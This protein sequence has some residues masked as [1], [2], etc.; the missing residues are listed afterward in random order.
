MG[1]LLCAFALGA[2]LIAPH[3]GAPAVM[4]DGKVVPPMSMLV[5]VAPW[6]AR[7][8]DAQRAYY[9]KLGDAGMRVFY[10]TCATSWRNP[11]DKAKGWPDGAHEAVA[12]VR[13]I[14]ASVPEA[15][16]I[17]RLNVSPPA[18]WVEAHPEEM[19]T[20]DD[21]SHRPVICTTIGGKPLSGMLS[22]CS[23]KWRARGAEALAAFFKVIDASDVADRVIGTF[24]CAGG[25]SEWYYPI[26]MV[27]QDGHCAGFCE[28][29]RAEYERYLRQKYG[30]VEAL[31]K[32][33]RRPEATF[34]RP[35]VPT[36]DE[37]DHV[38]KADAR[39]LG[40]LHSWESASRRIGG[41][42]KSA[43]ASLGVFLDLD[44]ASHVADFYD[45]WHEGVANTIVHF[46]RT[47]KAISPDRLV[48]AFYG[49]LGETGYY[50]L[51][52][53]TGTLRILDSGVVDFLAAPGTYN[54]REPGGI[55]AQR[56]VPDSFRLRNCIYIC[57]D[58]SRTHLSKPWMQRDAMA[59]YTAAESVETL[60]RDF[61][62]NL[63]EGLYGWWFDMGNGWYEDADILR[64]FRRQQEIAAEAYEARREKRNEI[65]LV[66]SLRSVHVVSDYTSKL[67]LDYW[68]TSDL[69]R[70]GAPVDR[71]FI[72][73]LAHPEMPDYK[74]YVMVNAYD[75]T[76]A[77]RAR[78]Y[79]KARR[80]AAT[81]L[82]LYAPGFVDRA[83]DARMSADNISKTVGMKVEEIGHTVFP[84]FRL[85][86]NLR[87]GPARTGKRYGVIDA[88]VHSNIWMGRPL[89]QPAYL[90]PAFRIVDPRAKV[91][92][93]FCSDR[94]VAL[95]AVM[96]NGVKSVYC[97]T[98][99]V[100]WDL[101]AGL[102]RV[103]GVHLFATQGDVLYA[104]ENYVCLHATGDGVRTVTFKRP[105]SPYEVYERKAYG[106]NVASLTV[107]MKHGE[108]RTWRIAARARP[109]SQVTKEKTKGENP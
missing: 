34:E 94:S 85:E 5:S 80:N 24:L 99:T 28:P 2:A 77:E 108:T 30:T 54:N 91:L 97:A 79:Q 43:P 76:D 65:A 53:A 88:D 86:P 37:Q 103:S 98:P 51:G 36:A 82:W 40:Q 31:R 104:D 50:A 64:L 48:G 3:N 13:E 16:V 66:H 44:R 17:L 107:K 60:K 89:I 8:R 15:F 75:L 109:V 26:A 23:G 10:V 78:V 27:T 45:A 1:F 105:C 35:L 81:V 11:G 25:T 6:N 100:Q 21:G 102:A 4:V 39:I 32:A 61:G 67:V 7:P 74:L 22:L 92:G 87:L 20:Y 29:F 59:L 106:E 96:T 14:L 101:L 42:G 58:D 56:E 84:H 95:A 63:C 52:T 83:A 47:L 33:W 62:R 70:I 12:S 19:V 73:D 18:E 71:Y 93:R 38:F 41:E 72:D 69:G 57:E 9:R 90:N 68:R 55:V 49:A 46:A